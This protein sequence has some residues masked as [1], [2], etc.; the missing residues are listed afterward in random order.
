MKELY[1]RLPVHK[2]VQHLEAWGNLAVRAIHI[3]HH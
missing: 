1:R 2:T 3:V